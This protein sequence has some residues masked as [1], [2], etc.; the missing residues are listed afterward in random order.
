MTPVSAREEIG[1]RLKSL[2]EKQPEV[3][4]DVDKITEATPFEEVGF[5]SIS[6]LDFM[7]EIEEDFGVQL[8]VKDLLDMDSVGDLVAHLQGKLA[9]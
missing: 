3:Q 5:D 1:A 7:Y 9:G 2:L 6:I 4:F 8:E